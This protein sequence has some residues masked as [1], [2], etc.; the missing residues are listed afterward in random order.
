MQPQSHRATEPQ[1]HRATEPSARSS[2]R[3]ESGCARRPKA[4]AVPARP[5]PCR[6][7]SARSRTARCRIPCHTVHRWAFR[8][9]RAVPPAPASL[10]EVI[11]LWHRRWRPCCDYVRRLAPLC[12][13]L[14][15]ALKPSCGRHAKMAG[16]GACV[17]MHGSRTC[18]ECDCAIECRL[19]SDLLKIAVLE[20][21]SWNRSFGERTTHLWTDMLRSAGQKLYQ[22]YH[23]PVHYLR[24]NRYMC[25]E[26]NRSLRQTGPKCLKYART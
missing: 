8:R 2:P 24:I 25:N 22:V 26:A 9:S 11:G 12:H 23:W 16:R 6:E 17:D 5:R 18:M 7:T 15:S 19:R 20:N 13:E 14:A 3:G 4:A 10:G 1:S 21:S